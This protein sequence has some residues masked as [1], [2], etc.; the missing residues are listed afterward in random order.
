MRKKRKEKKR[1]E[2]K[3]FLSIWLTTSLK[4]YLLSFAGT[5]ITGSPTEN[6]F[7]FVHNRTWICV[8]IY[9]VSVWVPID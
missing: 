9:L 7:C 4:P 5:V 6:S 1:K 3:P 8:S 2:K